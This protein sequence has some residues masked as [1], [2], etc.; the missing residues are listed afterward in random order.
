LPADISK[1]DGIQNWQLMQTG[2]F[3]SHAGDWLQQQGITPKTHFAATD[4]GNDLNQSIYLLKQPSTN[5]RRVLI[6][7]GGKVRYDT[8]VQNLAAAAQVPRTALRRITWSG[9]DPS[10]PPTG[11]G[12]LVIRSYQDPASGIVL[13][14]SGNQIELGTPRDFHTIDLQ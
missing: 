5:M 14:P 1:I 2:D 11:D 13:F 6:L 8:T 9:R 4:S 12:I 7:L 10:K 3:D